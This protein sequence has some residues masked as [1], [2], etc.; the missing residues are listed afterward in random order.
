MLKKGMILLTALLLCLAAMGAQAAVSYD[1]QTGT[2][3]FGEAEETA[4]NGTQ[5]GSR[6]EENSNWELS[7]PLEAENL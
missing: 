3:S 1:Q 2:E 7:L 6:G 5:D 4:W